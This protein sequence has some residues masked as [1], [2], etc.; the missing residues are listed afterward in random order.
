MF[1]AMA[2]SIDI[3][4]GVDF[5]SNLTVGNAKFR[6]S[7]ANFDQSLGFGSGTNTG[8]FRA[9]DLGNNPYLMQ[10]DYLLVLT[11]SP[12]DG[13]AFTMTRLDSDP[14]RVT[15]LSWSEANPI[16]G[17]APTASFN[18]IEIDARANLIGAT[19]SFSGISFIGIDLQRG[20]FANGTIASGVAP[21]QWAVA[22]IDL[23]KI[24]WTLS[25]TVHASRTAV[26]SGDEN[27]RF[28]MSMKQVDLPQGSGGLEA[29]EPSAM[30]AVALG[31][32][33]MS[34]AGGRRRQRISK[35]NPAPEA[36]R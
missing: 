8:T 19:M 27:V 1:P 22:D 23:S 29:P 11:Y 7:Q 10:S 15:S 20:S 32:A 12:V 18:A 31:S 9:N 17:V 3:L 33:L 30:T 6:M 2:A 5:G 4:G 36:M 24:P 21:A 26:A 16:N 28:V 14:A 35:K 25:A 34:I 13:F